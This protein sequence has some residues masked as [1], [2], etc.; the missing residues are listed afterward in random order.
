MAGS[1]Y[2]LD[3]PML[4]FLMNGNEGCRS[5]FTRKNG[6]FTNAPC[7]KRN[8][9]EK[10]DPSKWKSQARYRPRFLPDLILLQEVGGFFCP[11]HR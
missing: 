2:L 4:A 5:D 1:R 3:L 9:I 11:G 7:G 10:T 6:L 8:R